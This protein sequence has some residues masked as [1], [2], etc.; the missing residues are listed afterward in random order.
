MAILLIV[1]ALS[2]G[3]GT[4]S[5]QQPR[6]AQCRQ[7]L[8]IIGVALQ[9]AAADNQQRFP[10]TKGASFSDDIFAGLIP[11]YSSRVDV[12]RCPGR[13]RDPMVGTDVTLKN[14]RNHYAYAMG[15]AL[16]APPEQWLASDAQVSER[17]KRFGEVVFSQKASGPG[18]NHAQFGGSF[19]MVDGRVE[20][21]DPRAR[22]AVDVPTNG[23]LLNPR[24][25]R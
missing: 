19:L 10:A 1:A 20:A 16:T 7:N 6:L 8:Q 5:K 9:T 25:N 4:K 3:R 18:S 21:S 2:L 22:F 15:L 17:S 12:F 11:K 13:S 23:V 24:N 14:F